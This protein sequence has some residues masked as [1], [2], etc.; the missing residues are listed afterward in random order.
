MFTSVEMITVSGTL[1]DGESF[2]FRQLSKYPV[3]KATLELSVSMSQV[4]LVVYEL[5]FF[6]FNGVFKPERNC[7][8][9]KFG[10]LRNED[11]HIP[12]KSRRYRFVYCED[13]DNRRSCHG[14]TT[15]QDFIP[16]SV[17]FTI[18]IDCAE[19]HRSNKSV[20]SQDLAFNI[21]LYDASNRTKCSKDGRWVPGCQNYYLH[22]TLPN[23][24][25]HQFGYDTR[26]DFNTMDTWLKAI[27]PNYP[28][29]GCY[30]HFHEIMCYI[31]AP[32]CDPQTKQM[33]PP[34]R[35]ACLD[36]SQGC[37]TYFHQML[38]QTKI[39]ANEAKK[40]KNTQV[41]NCNYL[42]VANGTLPCFYK[43]VIC[44]V[45]P[46][47]ANGILVNVINSTKSHYLGSRLEYICQDEYDMKGN[48]TVT[49]LYSG[50]WSVAPV[51]E[52]KGH[53]SMG[54]LSIVLP[55]LIVPLT[56][57]IIVIIRFTCS[58]K[59]VLHYSRRHKRYDAFV[60]YDIADANY[61]HETIIDALEENCDPPFKLCIHKRDFKPSYT[62]KWNIWNAIKNSNSAIIV[63]S[64]SYVDSI[65]C[66]DEF[67]G[68]YVEN[69]EDPAFRLFVIM[70]Q[71]VDSLKN[72]D[73]YMKSFFAS[74]T[75]LEK[76][77]PK[78]FERIAEYL[79]K[80]KQPQKNGVGLRESDV[81]IGN[82]NEKETLEIMLSSV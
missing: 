32:K 43:Q 24:I 61:A 66:R 10:Q 51:C 68:C 81:N 6:I 17:A 7:S 16:R 37:T 72:T 22:R 41:A 63:M 19:K 54:P 27:Y 33:V 4:G 14:K 39:F 59:S 34:C 74:K 53:S 65:W 57:F 50:Q 67:E 3:T 70:M 12:L 48:G 38:L 75:Y 45:P 69:L 56:L 20:P 71:P 11:L 28:Q 76:D 26:N 9:Q 8:Y 73:E 79:Y 62:I 30:Q 1:A 35:E 47:L 21:S 78:V 49:C 15:V 80:V 82:N 25:G 31:L 60:C 46:D 2:Y 55:I 23:L 29:F 42:P 58:Q 77:D 52:Q 5:D 13:V 36:F 40:H 64:Q 18:G 44:P